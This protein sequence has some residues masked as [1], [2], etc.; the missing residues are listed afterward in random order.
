MSPSASASSN[1]DSFLDERP[2]NL[3]RADACHDDSR[4][5]EGVSWPWFSPLLHSAIKHAWD[6]SVDA[7]DVLRHERVSCNAQGPIT[8]LARE[9]VAM[10]CNDE[11]PFHGLWL[12]P[13]LGNILWNSREGDQNE[14]IFPTY[15]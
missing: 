3:C 11:R 13:G 10:P 9:Y 4:P 8:V 5:A 2:Y 15:C 6:L 7:D 1:G 12:A 14:I